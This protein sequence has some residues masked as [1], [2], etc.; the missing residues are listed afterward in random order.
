MLPQLCENG[1]QSKMKRA[2]N[3]I[4]TCLI[5]DGAL[6]DCIR[7]FMAKPAGQHHLSEIH[8]APQG[9][10]VTAV[11][12]VNLILKIARLRD[13]LQARRVTR[14][15]RGQVGPCL[16]DEA[17]RPLPERCSCV[18]RYASAR[19]LQQRSPRR[20]LQV[21]SLHLLC[22]RPAQLLAH[23]QNVSRYPIC[24]GTA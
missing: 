4:G 19:T 11:L 21:E 17:H 14:P 18:S 10:L 24:Q 13:F 12:S 23:V 22:L 7:Q 20:T 15:G 1:L 8:T 16:T 5:I 3:A 6:D 2:S 9:E